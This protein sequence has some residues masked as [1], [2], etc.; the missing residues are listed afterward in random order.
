[1]SHDATSTRC[2]SIQLYDMRLLLMEAKLVCWPCVASPRKL[3][4][5]LSSS[6]TGEWWCRFGILTRWHMCVRNNTQEFI[7]GR[8]QIHKYR[9]TSRIHLWTQRNTQEFIYERCV[10]IFCWKSIISCAQKKINPFPVE[11][12]AL[13]D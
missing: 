2:C 4:Y 9:G 7:Y 1:M 6:T 5:C 13:V 8:R 12:S 3:R 10:M 11:S